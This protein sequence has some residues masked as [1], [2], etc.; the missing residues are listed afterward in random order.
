MDPALPLDAAAPADR[1]AALRRELRAAVR[2][3]IPVAMVQLGTML[4]GVVDTI[5]LGHLS[6]GALAAGALGHVISFTLLI[7]GSGTLTVLDPLIS[8]AYGA[9]E[10][11]AISAHFQRGLVLAAALGLL[12]TAL[13]WNASPLLRALGQTPEVAENAG[14]YLRCLAWGNLALLLFTAL[15]QTLQAMS[16]VRPALFAIVIGN[17][18]NLL[19]N[20][21]LIFGHFGFPAVGVVGSAYAT[22]LAR[23]GMFLYLL[24]A[25]RRHLAPYWQ[26]FTREAADWGRYLRMLRLGLPLGLHMS[27]EL[28]IFATVALIIGHMGVAQLAGHQISLNLASVS[29]MIPLGIAGA[30]ATRVGNAIGRQDMP[31]AR[32]SAVVCLAL[33]SGVM[34]FFAALFALAPHWLAGIYSDDPAVIAVA[35]SLLPIAAAFQVLDGFQ[36]V[37]A[38]VLRGAADTNI[39]AITA[40]VGYWIVGLPLGWWLAVPH[41]LG[42]RGLWWALTVALFVVSALLLARIRMRF[43]SHIARA[44]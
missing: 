29:F 24:F 14:L 17:L 20:Y 44:V 41:G 35:A 33:G 34:L 42:P 40:L 3:S 25:G 16:V 27:I 31:G 23:W 28:G 12:F 6:A 18:F 22:S 7:L 2:L 43:R 39:P 30:A 32:L 26:G 10:H 8:Q 5:M 1:R 9:G 21:T 36:V 15:R 11:R 19:G 37:A 4:M 38:G 13:M